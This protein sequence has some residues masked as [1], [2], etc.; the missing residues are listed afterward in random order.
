MHVVNSFEVAPLK[1][2]FVCSTYSM[3]SGVGGVVR[4]FITK[5][6]RKLESKQKLLYLSRPQLFIHKPTKPKKEQFE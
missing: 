2:D 4:L 5:F 3:R 6:S 1:E